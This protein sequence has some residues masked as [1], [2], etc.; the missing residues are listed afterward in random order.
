MREVVLS[1]LAETDL[2]DIWVFVSQDNADAADHFSN[3]FTKSVSCWPL[4]PKRVE[5]DRSLDPPIRSFAVGSY[6][7]FYREHS[8][9]IEVARVLHGHRDIQSL[10][11]N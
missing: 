4:R 7:I 2:T 9:G 3:K 8:R 5:S 1:E 6:V 10:F 11:R